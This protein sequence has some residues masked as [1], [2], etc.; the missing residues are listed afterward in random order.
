MRKK[1]FVGLLAFF[2]FFKVSA[3]NVD[4]NWTKVESAIEK[5]ETSKLD[6]FLNKLNTIVNNYKNNDLNNNY[7][8]RYK[9]SKKFKEEDKNNFTKKTIT[10]DK[11][12]DNQ[13][14][15]TKYYD[16]L[17][18]EAPSYKENMKIEK[19]EITNKVTKETEK[20]IIL[21]SS[22]CKE[23]IDNIETKKGY[24]L[25]TNILDTTKKIDVNKTF[26]SFNKA[27]EELNKIIT[28]GGSGNV[29]SKRN[30]EKDTV[31]STKGTTPYES[32]DEALNTAKKLE[33]KTDTQETT[34]TIRK[35]IEKKKDTTLKI[36][37]VVTDEFDTLEQA[38][39]K[40]KQLEDEGYITK[41][42][43][44]QVTYNEENS[45]NNNDGTTSTT[46]NY[47]HLDTT[48]LNKV[49]IID[50]NG[51]KKEVGATMTVS[52]VTV[53]GKEIS[54][55]GP[56]KDPNTGYMEYQSKK[57]RLDIK[58]NAIVNISGEITYKLNG[59]NVKT[60]YNISGKLDESLNVC[61]GRGSAKGFDLKYNS[62]TILDNKAYV[63]ANIV[64]K[65]IITGTMYKYKDVDVYYVDTTTT[66][67]GFDYIL[68][69]SYDKNIKKLIYYFTYD[70]EVKAY[71]YQLSYDLKTYDLVEYE[72]VDWIIEK[73]GIAS[74]TNTDNTTTVE[75]P[76]TGIKSFPIIL[77]LILPALLIFGLKKIKKKI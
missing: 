24:N 39:N 64:T 37:D 56:S 40:I 65:Y 31:S 51:Q 60:N 75:I 55:T 47:S 45:D 68:A 30:K 5:V 32:E 9:L 69:A 73:Q 36:E 8:Y 17:K 70:E 50:D 66:N 26:D 63:D 59:Q 77:I 38:Q 61:G 14:E 1:F 19:K 28:E 23:E 54:L 6:T 57:R 72:S 29:D 43:I 10:V 42:T 62:I 52:K 3:I 76:K 41:A 27:N 12:F 20:K 7:Q 46:K 35:E 53:D 21:C 11:L 48:L 44:K 58:S 25:I 74:N 71:K 67:Y 15:A 18:I 16:G 22:D 2:T 49:T 34:T 33:S 13:E 4:T